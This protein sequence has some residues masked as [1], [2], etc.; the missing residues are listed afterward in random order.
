MKPKIPPPE[1]SQEKL[2]RK[3]F[4]AINSM[5]HPEQRIRAREIIGRFFAALKPLER[6]TRH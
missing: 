6:P 5:P 3:L 4:I 1:L 2:R